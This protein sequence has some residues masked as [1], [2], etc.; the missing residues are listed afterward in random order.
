LQCYN[1][2]KGRL[3]SC[4]GVCL[5]A[6]REFT[7]YD[8]TTSELTGCLHPPVTTKN[9]CGNFYV[10]EKS[11]SRPTWV[12]S[13]V[14]PYLLKMNIN[15]GTICVCDTNACNLGTTLGVSGLSVVFWVT[16]LVVI[17]QF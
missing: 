6:K 3:E 12:P 5:K 11:S 17:T 16:M 8:G 14:L 13:S 10:E 2:Y 7:A 9:D 15:K 1:S 4:D